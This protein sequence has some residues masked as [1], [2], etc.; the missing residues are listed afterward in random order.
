M[1]QTLIGQ[2][3]LVVSIALFLVGHI[4]VQRMTRIER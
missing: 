2:I 4:T 3:A 1:T